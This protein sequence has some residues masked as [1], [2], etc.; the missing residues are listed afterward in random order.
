MSGGGFTTVSTNG[1]NICTGVLL[2]VSAQA[3]QSG[4][5]SV[6]DFALFVSYLGWL[7]V[8]SRAR[9]RAALLLA[10]NAVWWETP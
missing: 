5:F 8:V 2:L 7:T 1:G 9:R 3:M 6:G 10:C 4:S